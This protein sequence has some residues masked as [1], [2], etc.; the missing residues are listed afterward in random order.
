MNKMLTVRIQHLGYAW[1]TH[2][3]VHLLA[4]GERGLT[5]HAAAEA[6]FERFWQ[7]H[8][9]RV[10]RLIAR[11]AGSVDLA[12]DLTQEVSVRAFQGFGAFRRGASGYTWLYRIAV[13][14]VL[15]HRER[16]APDTVSWDSALQV[17]DPGQNPQAALLQAEIRPTVW[18]ALGRLPEEQRTTIILSVYEELKYREIAAVLEIPLGT[19]KSRLHTGMARLREELKDAL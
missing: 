6:T 8:R 19:V 4:A 5:K 13:N 2:A 7:P 10:W 14:V 3:L 15:R 18:A 9:A 1:G 17:P 12:D 11:L 16:L